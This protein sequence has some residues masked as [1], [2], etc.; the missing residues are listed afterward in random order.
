MLPIIALAATLASIPTASRP[1]DPPRQLLSG[2]DATGDWSTD[3][4]GTRRRLTTKDLPEP[5]AT[6]SVD[7]GPRIVARPDGARPV[8]PQGFTVGTFASGLF[9]PRVVRALPSG[10][11]LVV[12]SAAGRIRLLRDTDRDGVADTNTIFMEGLKLPFGVV[13]FPVGDNPT[14]LYIAE[15]DQVIRVPYRSGDLKPSGDR[16]VVVADIPG[17]GRL[18]GGGHWT[19]DI[20][21][22]K[23]SKTLFV[24][25]GSLTNVDDPDVNPLETRRACI[26]AFRPDGSEERLYASGI[27][28]PVGL[29]IDPRRGTLWTAVNERDGLGDHLVPDYVTSVPENSFFGWPWFY[30]GNHPDPRLAGKRTE[31]ARKV[32][33]PDVLVQS[34]SAALDLTFYNGKQFPKEYSGHVFACLH[35]SWNRSRRTGY[36]VVRI[37]VR[38]GRAD[39]SYED[40]LTGFVVD[41]QSVWGRPVGVTVGGDGAL[42]VSDDGSGT[43]W[44]VAWTGDQS[45]SRP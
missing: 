45:P 14:H 1:A 7:N 5:Y 12:E 41:N 20:E 4:P 18:R 2:V 42:Y 9:G 44:R 36:K 22:S 3:K 27:R 31:L 32:R 17:G 34:H 6:V 8:G 39:G 33:T 40:F 16:Q 10:D 19:R 29:A 30:L 13:A 26:L 28:N 35:G 23:D 37:P 43:I 24:S 38:N 25:V 21:F 15:T 11:I